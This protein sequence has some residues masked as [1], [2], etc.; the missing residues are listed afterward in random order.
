LGDFGETK[1]LGVLTYVLLHDPDENV[2]LEAADKLGDLH[3]PYSLDALTKALKDVSPLVRKEAIEGLK[4]IKKK[5]KPEDE[6]K[7]KPENRDE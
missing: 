3:H 7:G 6:N 2:R 1:V 5:N 4:K